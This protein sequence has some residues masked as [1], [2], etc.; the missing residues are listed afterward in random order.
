MNA[1]MEQAMPIREV[2]DKKCESCGHVFKLYETSRG[3]LG[4]C[5]PCSDRKVLE[6]L[7][8][9]SFE[10]HRRAREMERILQYEQVSD[11]L[12]EATV[13][14]YKPHNGS[15]QDAKQKTV[16]FIRGF[17]QNKSQSLVLS[18]EPGLGKSHL[19]YAITKAIR[20]QEYTALFIKTKQLFDYVKQAYE[21]NSNI[22]EQKLYRML[23]DLDLLVLD[24][25]GSEYTKNADNDFESWGSSI[26][27]KVLDDRLGKANVYTTNY[28]SSDLKAKYGMSGTR[29]F[30]RMGEQAWS[31]RLQGEDQRLN[32]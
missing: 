12:K 4:A 32:K 11:D 2:G 19:A 9:P 15:Q 10:A 14:D 24:D 1:V 23:R 31:V 13:N 6:N 16:H 18:G 3:V 26:I 25:I 21:P 29:I 5:K 22:S 7:H 27:E 28:S 20:D 17:E 8:L 30:S